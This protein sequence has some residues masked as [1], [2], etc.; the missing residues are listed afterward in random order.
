MAS[1]T[2]TEIFAF[3]ALPAVVVGVAGA[4]SLFFKIWARRVTEL[5]SAG[6]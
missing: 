5:G 3:L 1:M 2:R 4:A 6:R